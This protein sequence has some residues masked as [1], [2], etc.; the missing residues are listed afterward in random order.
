MIWD[1]LKET[2][3]GQGMDWWDRLTA[4]VLAPEPE[5]AAS[6]GE[7]APPVVWLLGRTGSGK[8]SLIAALTGDSRAQVGDGIRP[9]TRASVVYDWPPQAPLLRFL[10]TRGLGEAGYDPAEDLALAR[11]Q[12]HVLL[13]VAKVNDPKQAAVLA[14]LK[15]IRADRRRRQW[16]LVVAQTGLH[17]LYPRGAD[18]P[19][20]YPYDPVSGEADA[21]V[22]DP[23]RLALREQ[24]ALF[25]GL[26]GPAPHFVPV[27]F[28]LPEDGFSDPVFGLEALHQALCDAGIGH[29][30]RQEQAAAADDSAAITAAAAPLI[31]GYALSAAAAG[32]VPVPYLGV[33]GLVSTAALLLRALAGRFGEDWT[34]SRLAEFGAALGTATL[35]GIGA[36]YGAREAA[37]LIPVAGTVVAGALNAL[38]AG[39][40]VYALGQAA[41]VY[42]SARREGRAVDEAAV[43]AAF[44]Q[45]YEEAKRMMREKTA[46][47]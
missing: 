27:D 11:D 47:P 36:G 44:T 10:D 2:L 28:T 32:A 46:A 19:A 13:V 35:L 37:K 17:T 12:A 41:C 30:L 22:P 34:R 43:R 25:S 26:P 33:G 45:A 6:S 18:H 7:R 23:L 31:R 15:E 14:V 38:A 40:V 24:R 20:E 8:T 5:V 3:S 16:P 42:L 4:A 9:C 29:C 39:A 1:R 21:S